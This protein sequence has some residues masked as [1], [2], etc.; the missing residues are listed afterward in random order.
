LKKPINHNFLIILTGLPASGK[1]TFAKVLKKQL[2]QT[3]A[4]DVEIV[5]PDMIREAISPGEFNY[6]KERHVKKVMIKKIK[7]ALKKKR[8]VINDDLNYYTSMRHDLKAISDEFNIPFFILYISTPL[9]TCSTW[10]RVRGSPISDDIIH[11]IAR[12]FD[13]F[14]NY[15]WDTPYATLDFSKV[16]NLESTTTALLGSLKKE[17]VNFYKNIEKKPQE[18]HESEERSQTIDRITRIVVHNLLS[19]ERMRK[20]KSRILKLRKAYIREYVEGVETSTN[21]EDHFTKFLQKYLNGDQ[22]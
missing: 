15:Q 11:E 22:T 8:I 21:L 18:Q 12:K 16:Q 14:G 10:N 13:P 7:I 19:D 17:L 2:I 1:S 4:I 9:E 6:R 3:Y 20:L 5:D